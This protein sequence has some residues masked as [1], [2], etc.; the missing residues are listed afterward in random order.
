MFVYKNVKIIKYSYKL[1][2]IELFDDDDSFANI[3]V[4]L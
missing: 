3:A 1:S 4:V 2:P